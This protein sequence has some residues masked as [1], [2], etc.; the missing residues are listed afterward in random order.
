MADGGAPL[1]SVVIPV[2]NSERT[3]GE[4]LA[5]VL[6]AD[7]P[8]Q[9]R[10]VIVVDN[11]S[12]D[13]TGRIVREHPVTCLDE[14]RRGPSAARNRGIEAAGAELVAFTDADCVVTTGW[15]RALV[16]GF[17]DRDASGV[18]GEIVAFPPRTPAQRYTAMRKERWQS[19]AL[20]A[21]RP[22]AVTANVAFRRET[23]DQVGRFDPNL[24][25]A[26]DKDFGWRFFG[27]GLKM[28][29]RP[30]ALV[31]HRHRDD[32]W[33]LFV[34]HFGWGYGAARLHE[35]YGLPWELRHELRKQREL[36]D[37]LGNVG[38]SAVRR[39]RGE[40]DD[41]DLRNRA[42]EVVRRA[43]QRAGGL[44]GLASGRR[45]GRPLGRGPA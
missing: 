1:V 17:D 26:Q 37:A 7:Y 19:S 39:L 31:L 4:C 33:G 34:Q 3:I 20:T 2:R 10:E 40:G 43:G 25:R 32:A 13:L 12:T 42:F 45:I 29:Y 22:F 23:F 8:A 18:A 38:A 24:I 35:K 16:A 27:A 41:T 28:A 30:D 14:R 21:N 5:S 6:G 36:V 11:A 9:R 44:Y 15:L